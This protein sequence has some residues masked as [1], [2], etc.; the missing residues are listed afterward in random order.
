MTNSVSH[1]K[2]VCRRQAIKMIAGG[3]GSIAL[4]R[5]AL[6]Q[7]VE[8]G[9]ERVPGTDL[10]YFLIPFDAN[11]IERPWGTGLVSRRAIT[12]LIDEPI[13]DVFIFSHGWKGDVPAARE[14]YNRWLSA[15]N[16]CGADLQAMRNTP[17]GFHPLLI[18]LHWPSLPWGDEELPVAQAAAGA[19]AAETAIEELVDT[20]AQRIAD[21][22]QSRQALRTIFEAA[23]QPAPE[24]LPP[25][26]VR[27]YKTLESESGTRRRGVAAAPGNDGHA[28]NP[29]KCYR[30]LMQ[31]RG[32]Q[33]AANVAGGLPG[34]EPLLE[35][36]R[37][38]SFWMMKKRARHVGE[39]GSHRLLSALQKAVPA[40]RDVRFHLMGHSFGCIV[41]SATIAGPPGDVAGIQPVASLALVQ[42][43]FSI[44]SYCS[45]IPFSSAQ[46]RPGYF[47]SIIN[48]SLVRGPILTTQSSYDT[49]VGTWY[50]WAAWA[51]GA[52]QLFYAPSPEAEQLPD[53]AAVGAFGIQGEGCDIT[54]M[55][56]LPATG[57][58]GFR[59]G[60]I[61]NID[62]S[63]IISADEGASGAHSDIAH[64]EVAHAILE[65]AIVANQEEIYPPSPPPNPPVP[66][67]PSPCRRRHRRRHRR[68]C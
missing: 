3:M 16:D 8:E 20:Y 57:R 4:A 2:T 48:R 67:T 7:E 23:K 15:F 13:T 61:Y 6:S 63:R 65:A 34:L 55:Q 56:I 42:G 21:T 54:A 37:I 45:R 43:A 39:T 36:L 9:I 5:D 62:S 17:R 32:A 25:H 26:L 38:L 51:G 59:Q 33:Q 29:E 66:P 41:A 46:G 24:R 35:P 30:S 10:T 18:G 12:R 14:Q 1:S 68:R 31:R 44:W 53:Y 11:G 40:G 28:F 47:R 64:A 19:A 52:D 60:K 27:A 50:P 22:R 58:Y 49:A